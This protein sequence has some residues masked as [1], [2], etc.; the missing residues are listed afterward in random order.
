MKFNAGSVFSSPFAAFILAVMSTSDFDLCEAGAIAMKFQDNSTEAGSEI[1]MDVD[2]SA[3]AENES[4]IVVPAFPAERIGIADGDGVSL[5]PTL[6]D[7]IADVM[8]PP[9]GNWAQTWEAPPT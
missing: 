8:G 7:G 4:I 1:P 5:A 9:P 3:A 6:Q 2:R